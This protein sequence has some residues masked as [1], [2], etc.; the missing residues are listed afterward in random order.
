MQA[1]S[2][3]KALQ[4]SENALKV[5]Q[6]AWVGVTAAQLD[7]PFNPKELIG[8]RATITNT[9]P[10]PALNMTA[11]LAMVVKNDYPLPDDFEMP[12]PRFP[13]HSSTNLMSGVVAPMHLVPNAEIAATFRERP[14]KVH[15]YILGKIEYTDI[16]GDRHTTRYCYFRFEDEPPG[17]EI[18]S[19]K[20]WNS[21]D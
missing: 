20:T 18:H 4:S 21:M 11:T 10:S 1:L 2:A 6:R 5:T 7:A 19:C 17:T 16:F 3:E 15:V 12:Q 14:A 8:A 9:G 13:V